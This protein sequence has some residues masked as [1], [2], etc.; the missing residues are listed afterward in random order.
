MIWTIKFLYMGRLLCLNWILCLQYE[1]PSEREKYRFDQY[2]WCKIP[3][4]PRRDQINHNY[5]DGRDGPEWERVLWRPQ[6]FLDNY[7]PLTFLAALSK[8]R[9]E[10]PFKCL[11]QV[12]EILLFS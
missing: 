9:D 8:N 10:C 7:V 2:R 6:P 5:A 12:T 3:D 4:M 11:S 1:C